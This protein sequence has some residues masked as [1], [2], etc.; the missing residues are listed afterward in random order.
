MEITQINFSKYILGLANLT[1]TS[2]TLIY[3]VQNYLLNV[4]LYINFVI[5]DYINLIIRL[6]YGLKVLKKYF[7]LI[8]VIGYKQHNL[9]I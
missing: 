5:I 4:V 2:S 9:I 6:N 7:I 8:I 1:P 3:A